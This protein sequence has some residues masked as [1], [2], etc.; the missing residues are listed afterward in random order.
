MSNEVRL[1]GSELVLQVAADLYFA[2]R[3]AEGAQAA[4]GFFALRQEEA[5]VLRHAE[6]ERGEPASAGEGAVANTGVD[7]RDGDAL[8]VAL[9]ENTR[10]EFAFDE[11]E[12]SGLENA[13][14]GA[15]GEGEVK[16]EEEDGAAQRAQALA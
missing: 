10:P 15:D 11:Q 14:V 5:D 12:Q 2:R 6:P 8:A 1:G 9:R 7:D 16:G 3:D 13:E 4:G